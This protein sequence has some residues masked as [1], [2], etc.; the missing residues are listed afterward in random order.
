VFPLRH[1]ALI[2]LTAEAIAAI[3]RALSNHY[4]TQLSREMNPAAA[5]LTDI[6][7]V[8]EQTAR[9]NESIILNG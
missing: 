5:L 3:G 7:P 4:L 9:R 6:V 8:K 1:T 2:S